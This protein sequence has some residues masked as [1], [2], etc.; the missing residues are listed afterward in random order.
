VIQISGTSGISPAAMQLFV[1]SIHCYP[2]TI[3]PKGTVALSG[4]L[5]SRVTYSLLYA[6]AVASGNLAVTDGAWTAGQFSLGDGS[7]NFRIPDYRGEF[8]RF[9]D[10]GRG[11]D[12]GRGIGV[13]QGD[14]IK[15]HTHGLNAAIMDD[16]GV[17]YNITGGT[18]GSGVNNTGFNI[19][20][21]ATETRVRN[22]AYLGCIFTGVA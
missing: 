1:G 17:A 15:S 20:G 6:F 22:V 14:S 3:A 21:N 16:G 4:Q 8:G 5:L 7:T 18:R 9:F 2:A 12:A 10:N 11:V 19:G 13:A